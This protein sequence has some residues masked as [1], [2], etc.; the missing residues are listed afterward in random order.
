MKR[1]LSFTLAVLMTISLLS[2]FSA[3]AAD[4][5][6]AKI[7]VR[8]GQ[9]E[10][11][12]MLKMVNN[13]RTGKDAWYWNSD[14]KTKTKLTDLEKLD[15][16]YDL[17][18]KAMLRAAET[19]LSF[20]HER[21][22]GQMCFSVIDSFSSVGENICVG[23]RTAE[24]AFEAWQETDYNY[25][26][27][28]HRRNMLD[29]DFTAIGIGHVVYNGYDYWVQEFRAPTSSAKDHGACDKDKNVT[30]E[31]SSS[32]IYDFKITS[33]SK[34][35]NIQKGSK[36][37]LPAVSA[38]VLLYEAFPGYYCK[39]QPV[40]SW[41]VEDSSVAVIENGKL[42][43]LK[44]GQTKIKTSVFG[45][46]Y[47]QKVIV[48]GSSLKSVT[49]LK[50]SSI[51]SDS[52]KLSWSKFSGAKY[53]KIEKSADGKTWKTVATTSKT[54]FTVSKLSA[55]K[56]Y[57]FRVTALNSSKKQISAES[58]VLKTGTLTNSP[59][60]KLSSTQSRTVRATWKKITGASKY[61]VYKSTDAKKWTKVGSTTKAS[62]TLTK[63]TAGK[64]IYVKITALNAYDKESSGKAVSVTVRK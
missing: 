62:F 49:G 17:E 52:L 12:S 15:Y 56:K 3:S 46:S 32:S 60:V 42:V 26:G 41:K 35:I 20:A 51:K 30:V 16:D 27:Q 6:K 8:Y 48:K 7:K 59:T 55:G 33:G 40:C 39:V 18:E 9:T 4:I 58:S 61:I 31:I 22:N 29:S 14:N 64:K 57:Q 37:D 50:A 5:Y 1:I 21:P 43:G 13:F 54:S 47:S 24:E 53:Y 11:R 19:A 23:F 36:V 25:S 10:A 45:K 34:E 44:A 63:L 28:G 38:E 2:F